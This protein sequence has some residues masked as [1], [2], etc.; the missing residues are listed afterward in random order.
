[1]CLRWEGIMSSP[2]TLTTWRPELG[3]EEKVRVV[4]VGF[5]RLDPRPVQGALVEMFSVS[6]FEVYEL[7]W[8]S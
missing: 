7:E 6:R 3:Y 8:E 1:M 5:V 2:D 4:Y